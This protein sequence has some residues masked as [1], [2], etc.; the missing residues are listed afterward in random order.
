MRLFRSAAAALSLALLFSGTTAAF[1]KDIDVR[2]ATLSTYQSEFRGF[3]AKIVTPIVTGL[4]VDEVQNELN[5]AFMQRARQL[6]ANYEKD[7]SEMMKDDP[8][9]D[10]H[11]GVV[12]DYKVRTD[13]DKVLAVD[14]Y[15]MNIAGSS[16]TVHAFYNFDK[17]SGKLIELGD[18]FNEKADYTKVINDYILGEMRRINKKE[19]GI[20][21]IAPKDEQGFRSI[22]AKQNFFINDKGNIVI[23]FDKYEVAPGA[24]GSPEFEIPRRVAAPYLAKK[25]NK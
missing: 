14:I 5:G 22:K 10:G 13:N 21:W 24:A 19:K 4:A 7:V 8:A 11:M 23:C 6:A 17:K 1:A 25:V 3:E 9:F 2:I 18:L 16:S 20:F 12:L 15:E